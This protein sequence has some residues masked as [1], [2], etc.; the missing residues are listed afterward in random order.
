MLLALPV[1]LFVVP[2]LTG[3]YVGE[4]RLARLAA[5]FVPAR[6]RAACSLPTTARRKPR[7]LPRGGQ[8]IAASPAVRPP[9]VALRLAA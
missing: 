6:R 5:V 7:A 2:L 9:P 3:C 4:E 1:L 8:L